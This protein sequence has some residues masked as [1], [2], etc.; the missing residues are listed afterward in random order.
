MPPQVTVTSYQG[1]KHVLEHA[2][3]FN[4][5]WNDGLEWLMGKGGR[6]SMLGGDTSF[7]AKQKKL[8]NTSLYRD[9]WHEEVKEFFEYITLKLL[10]E[11]SCKIAGIN[12]V[13]ITREWVAI[14][15]RVRP[16]L[17]LAA[18]ATLHM[19]ISQRMSSHSP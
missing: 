6:D 15:T 17:T 5:M 4:V 11:K 9:K 3:E 7:H 1:A 12:Q 14:S 13:D 18:W 19:S 10:T 16:K 8:M 2:Q